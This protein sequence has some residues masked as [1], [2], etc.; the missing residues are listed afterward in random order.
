MI[1][2]AAVCAVAAGIGAPFLSVRGQCTGRRVHNLIIMMS[3]VCALLLGGLPAGHSWRIA[4][5][6]EGPVARP[7]WQL[8]GPGGS[9]EQMASSSA[10]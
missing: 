7:G 6:V 4:W 5:R 9:G 10:P 1:Q 2:H 3:G 8:L